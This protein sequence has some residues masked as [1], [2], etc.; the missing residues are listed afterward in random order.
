MVALFFRYSHT[1]R[2]YLS[3]RNLSLRSSLLLFAQL[4][5]GVV[6]MVQHGIAHRDLKSDN[7]LIEERGPNSAHLVISDFGCC[8]AEGSGLK[9]PYLSDDMF[10]GGNRALMAPEVSTIQVLR[11]GHHSPLTTQRG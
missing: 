8:L 11:N 1:L 9:M 10:R 4:L 5:E 6:H 2:E 3:E 7:V